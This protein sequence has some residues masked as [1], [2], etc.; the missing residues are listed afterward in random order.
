MTNQHQLQLKEKKQEALK[1]LDVYKRLT[2]EIWID[3]LCPVT[4]LIE[5]ED[6]LENSTHYWKE[7]EVCGRKYEESRTLGYIVRL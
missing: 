7:C 2:K 3:C 4:D 1:A 6:Y 5:R